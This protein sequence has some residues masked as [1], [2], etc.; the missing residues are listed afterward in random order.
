[1][2]FSSH[3]VGAI[4][5]LPKSLLCVPL[6]LQWLWLGLRHRSLT[7]PSVVN[8][9]I[10]AGGLAGESKW[11]CLGM[12]GAEHADWVARTIAVA[13]DQ[14][15]TRLA[16]LAGLAFPLIAKPDI[17]WCGYGV[18]LISNLGELVRY[19]ASFP[20]A[21]F[22]LQAFVPGPYEAGLFYMR[23]PGEA[24]G[25]LIAIAMRHQPRVVGDGR[26]SITRLITADARLARSLNH[27]RKSL[28]EEQLARVP[29]D[30][31]SVL[32][33]NV[34]SLRVG[35]RYENAMRLH[36]PVLEAQ[37]DAISRSMQGFNFGRF[38]VRFETETD[39]RAGKFRIIEV[40]GAGSEAIEFWDPEFSLIEAFRGVFAKQVMLFGLASEMR[41]A[42]GRPIGV[43][44][45][46]RA[47]LMQLRLMR[48]YPP[49]N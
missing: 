37:V 16:A 22:L 13:P 3:K 43:P 36:T 4:E 24:R 2:A 21:S 41:T 42:G 12:I 32:L 33:S 29:A 39:L 28:G 45:L 48:A 5:R 1:L 6:I 34:A 11:A 30:T 20:R 25:R 40:N 26:S 19:A 18:Q 17:G 14:D 10:E 38:D 15:A 49:S 27:F 46:A 8:P 23:Q 7:L 9:A 31:E 44:A 35:G 47:W